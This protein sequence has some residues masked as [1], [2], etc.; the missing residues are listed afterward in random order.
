MQIVVGDRVKYSSYVKPFDVL[1]GVVKE[2]VPDNR[3]KFKYLIDPEQDNVKNRKIKNVKIYRYHPWE[4]EDGTP[5]QIDIED[6]IE[7]INDNF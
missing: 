1:T 2:I 4:K 5:S 6:V 3:K 7:V